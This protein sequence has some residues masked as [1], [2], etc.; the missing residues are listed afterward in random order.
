M[1]YDAEGIVSGAVHYTSGTVTVSA[2]TNG[3]IA[4]EGTSSVRT[5]FDTGDADGVYGV[6]K[7]WASWK[8]LPLNMNTFSFASYAPAG[9]VFHVGVEDDDWTGH[10]A[11]WWGMHHTPDI[12]QTTHN[13]WQLNTVSLADLTEPI[14]PATLGAN[15]GTVY[16]YIHGAQW[17]G[18][19]GLSGT[20][21]FDAFQFSAAAD[22]VSAAHNWSAYE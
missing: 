11:P 10:A 3:S 15:V 9:T 22:P 7:V 8:Q 12:T 20:A 19:S 14:N 13:G 21:Y 2:P 5:D 18:Q 17:G 16:I 1:H 6:I 4:Y